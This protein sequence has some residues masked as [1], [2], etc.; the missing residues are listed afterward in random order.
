MAPAFLNSPNLFLIKKKSGLLPPFW[1]R[2]G[3]GGV[4]NGN[5][6][7][8]AF[9]P[10]PYPSPKGRGERFPVRELL[11]FQ[12]RGPDRFVHLASGLNE[13]LVLFAVPDIDCISMILVN[14]SP[15]PIWI[16]A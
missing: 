2:G 13:R 9:V 4:H 14:Q 10:S 5:G 16:L 8:Y 1:Q 12:L 6:P 7:P 15:F 3:K 11:S